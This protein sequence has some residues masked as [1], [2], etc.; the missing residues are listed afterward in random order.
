MLGDEA[1]ED[2]PRRAPGQHIGD[3][4]RR[5]RLLQRR[6]M[7]LLWAAEIGGAELHAR[8]AERIGLILHATLCPQSKACRHVR[9]VEPL[10]MAA[11]LKVEAT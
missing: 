3:D 11:G 6:A 1:I 10:T 4:G 9:R 2:R 8:C 5:L 7:Q